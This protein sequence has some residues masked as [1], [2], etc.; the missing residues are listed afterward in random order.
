MLG[1][2][3][4]GVAVTELL[5]VAEE[6][7]VVCLGVASAA[8]TLLGIGV[9]TYDVAAATRKPPPTVKMARITHIWSNLSNHPHSSTR[10]MTPKSPAIR[11]LHVHAPREPRFDANPLVGTAWGDCPEC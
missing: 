9:P 5:S 4:F 10:A 7:D 2:A 11:P 6:F 8:S 3:A 1:I